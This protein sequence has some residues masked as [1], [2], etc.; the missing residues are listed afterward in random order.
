MECL[1][2]RRMLD[3]A[4]L[5]LECDNEHNSNLMIRSGTKPTV[6]DNMKLTCVGSQ[7]IGLIDFAILSAVRQSP[8]SL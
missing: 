4:S 5:D 3:L 7:L 8:G 6:T 1:T 2:Y